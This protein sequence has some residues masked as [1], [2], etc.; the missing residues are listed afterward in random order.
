M[1]VPHMTGK[2]VYIQLRADVGNELFC[3]L[4]ALVLS[5]R[6]DLSFQEVGTDYLAE[7]PGILQML[8]ICSGCDYVSSFLQHPKRQFFETILS[9]CKFIT[10]G[11]LP[12]RLNEFQSSNYHRGLLSFYRLVGSMYFRYHQ[13]AFP[14]AVSCDIFVSNMDSRREKAVFG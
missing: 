5:F 12:G 11:V 9:D 2:E 14:V 13:S 8:Y 7:L 1:H 3:N 10:G 6:S 4:A